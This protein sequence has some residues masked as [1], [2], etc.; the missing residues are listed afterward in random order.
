M[1]EVGIEAIIR[2]I[3][4]QPIR[5]LLAITGGGSRAIAELLEVPGGS[6][7]LIEAIVP[8]SAA[9]LH[10]YLGAV[11]EKYVAAGTARSMAAAGFRRARRLVEVEARRESDSVACIAATSSLATDR[12]KLGEH[13]VHL[14]WQ[15]AGTTLQWSLVFNKGA[16]TR[17]QEEQLVAAIILN[18][19]AAATG[20]EL[21]LPINLLPGE[22]AH[23][24]RFDAPSSWRRLLLGESNL[25]TAGEMAAMGGAAWPGERA[26]IFSGAFNPLHHGHRQ[27][28]DIALRRYALP[29]IYEICVQNVDKPPLDFLEMRNRARQFESLGPPLVFT[30]AATFV[31][32]SAIFPNSIFAV[33]VDTVARIAEP[34]YYA[35]AAARDQALVDI[36]HRGCRFL[37][38]GRMHDGQFRTLRQLELPAALAALC[39]EVPAQE[40]RVDQSSTE[41]RVQT[42]AGE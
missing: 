28:A 31:D 12:P 39:D 34:R 24:D 22:Q 11:P 25:A 41:L 40:F 30:R 15:T 8:Y 26:L 27:M 16:R 2:A 33:G 38:F 20:I 7:C 19:I 23:E 14:A 18:Q 4:T 21:R 37:V 13:R 6:S 42:S 36:A 32:K 35:S 10:E 5:L 3:H 1:S 17:R 29:L 9:A